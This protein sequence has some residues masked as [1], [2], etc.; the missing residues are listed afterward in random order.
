MSPYR[1]AETRREDER[2]EAVERQHRIFIGTDSV[3]WM[4][5]IWISGICVGAA[6]TLGA[7]AFFGMGI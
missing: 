6:A 5:T 2:L 7:L 1:S 4:L 3:G